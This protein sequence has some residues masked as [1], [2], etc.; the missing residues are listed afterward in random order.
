MT[1]YHRFFEK[2]AF[3]YAKKSKKYSACISMK[4]GSKSE[5]FITKMI[6]VKSSINPENFIGFGRGRRIDWRN[7]MD[8][9]I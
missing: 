3:F 7:P 2:N 1:Y 8:I 6:S 9:P 4:T 5:K